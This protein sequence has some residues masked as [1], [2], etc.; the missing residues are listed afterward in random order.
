MMPSARPD[1]MSNWCSSVACCCAANTWIWCACAC[2]CLGVRPLG[3]AR[4][5][6]IPVPT[7]V[8]TLPDAWTPRG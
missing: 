5:L 4:T 8:T 6:G 7:R 1:L 2:N 3:P